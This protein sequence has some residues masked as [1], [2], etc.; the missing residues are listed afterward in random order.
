MTKE[1]KVKF[2]NL[3]NT[4]AEQLFM[5]AF[6]GCND[7]NL[8]E[9]FEEFADKTLSY[10]DIIDDCRNNKTERDELFY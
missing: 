9:L 2:F 4:R 8:K 1:K 5:T 6:S 3:T 7:L 10:K